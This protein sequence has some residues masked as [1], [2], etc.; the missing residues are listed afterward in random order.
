M[1]FAIIV[2]IDEQYGIGKDGNLAWSLPPDMAY[3]KCK[4]LSTQDPEK[5]NAVIMG[6]NTWK[7]IPNKFRPL[8]N[9]HNVILSLNNYDSLKHKHEN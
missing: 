7:S 3:F 5:Q 6:H 2:A 8:T 9:R 4:T 1:K